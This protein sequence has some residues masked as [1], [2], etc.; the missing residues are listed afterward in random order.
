MP[1][2]AQPGLTGQEVT[3]QVLTYDDPAK[4]I[5]QGRQHRAQIG[6]GVEFGAGYEGTQND[7]D[8]VPVLVDIGADRIELR[9]SGAEPGALWKSGFNGYVLT[10]RAPCDMIRRATIDP[11]FTT[12]P[13]DNKRLAVGVNEVRINVSDQVYDRDSRIAV[14]LILSDCPSS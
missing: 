8:V 3:F 14:D 13:M 12:L 5:F 2:L 7:L 1:A 4:P 9:Y 6:G 11:A 10:F